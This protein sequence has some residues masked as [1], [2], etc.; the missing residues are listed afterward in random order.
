MPF[1]RR[2]SSALPAKP[3]SGFVALLVVLF[4]CAYAA[5]TAAGPVAPGIRPGV[6][7]SG[8][9]QPSGGDGM[10]DMGGM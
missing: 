10:A 7:P 3:V 9:Q 6:Q 4:V 2:L 1:V 5:G 8:P